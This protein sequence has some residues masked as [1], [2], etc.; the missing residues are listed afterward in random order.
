MECKELF[1]RSPHEIFFGCYLV[2]ILQIKVKVDSWN[3][4]IVEW[5]GLEGTARIMNLQ[6]PAAC[7]A[8]N[9]HI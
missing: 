9:L 6:P 2:T 4:R 3:Y 5:V 7:R 8:T 1:G